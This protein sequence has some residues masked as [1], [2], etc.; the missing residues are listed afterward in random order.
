ME[1]NG[2][3][4]TSLGTGNEGSTEQGS[5]SRKHLGVSGL[6][7]AQQPPIRGVDL[8]L[9]NPPQLPPAGHISLHGVASRAERETCTKWGRTVSDAGCQSCVL[10][11]S[12]DDNIVVKV[13]VACKGRAAML[14]VRL[15]PAVQCGAAGTTIPLPPRSPAV[16]C[17]EARVDQGCDLLEALG[18]DLVRV[19]PSTTRAGATHREPTFGVDSGHPDPSTDSVGRRF[20]PHG[21]T[22]GR[23]GLGVTQDN[24][25]PG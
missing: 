19:G 15:G 12:V 14:A 13:P 25:V 16:C 23:G 3:Q 1:V 7:R 10:A 18:G 24:F 22:K 5:S 4:W 9:S 17:A 8:R 20:G 21:V 2:R 11:G 6:F